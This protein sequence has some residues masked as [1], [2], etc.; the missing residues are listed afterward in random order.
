MRA[1]GA[2]PVHLHKVASLRSGRKRPVTGG[3]SRGGLAVL[4]CPAL[5]SAGQSPSELTLEALYPVA[6]VLQDV[7]AVA[8]WV[9][10]THTG[11]IR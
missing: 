2:R 1:A 8:S 3:Q 11:L 6:Y 7:L 10:H 4:G 9:V 5:G